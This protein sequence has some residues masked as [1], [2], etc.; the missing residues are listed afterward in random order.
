MPLLSVF[1][2]IALNFN[3]YAPWKRTNILVT[4]YTEWYQHFAVSQQTRKIFAIPTYQEKNKNIQK[5]NYLK[6]VALVY[7][8]LG[9]SMTYHL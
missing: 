7:A 6:S 1:N 9:I 8:F 2:L 5:C 4:L 3:Q